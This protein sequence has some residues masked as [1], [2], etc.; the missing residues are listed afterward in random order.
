MASRSPGWRSVWCLLAG[1]LWCGA[2]TD[3]TAAE[4]ASPV[5]NH[6]EGRKIYNFRC[7]F[8][9]GYSGNARTLAATYLSPRPRNFVATEPDALPL[10][11]MVESIRHGRPQTAMAAFAGILN[12]QEIQQVAA[13]VREEF[14]IRHAENTRYH[15]PEN[16]WPQHEQYA[17]AFP[18]A[19]GELPLDGS[20]EGLSIA[21]QRGKALFFSACITCHDR[22]R[23][24]DEGPVWEAHAVSY[25]RGRYS[26]RNPPVDATT[27]ASPF[28]KHD[29]PPTRPDWSPQE[30]RGEA[31][32]QKNCAFCHAADGTGKHWIGTFLDPKPRDLTQLKGMKRRQLAER[33]RTGLPGTAMP[34]W[35]G[36]LD[37]GQIDDVIHYLSRA[38]HPIDD[39]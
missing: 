11:R 31:I 12:E 29:I 23:V 6:E 37:D 9:H 7:Y 26:H 36:I 10:A 28:A 35:R 2:V 27:T 4:P 13:F 14:M 22:A 33:I 39:D 25:P 19:T 38:M 18:F 24:E 17:E 34:A 8:C 5:D 3:L 32:F 1:L 16:G 20:S 21:Q 30:R 15:T